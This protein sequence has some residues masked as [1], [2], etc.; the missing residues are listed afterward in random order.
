MVQVRAATADDHEAYARLFPE[1]GVDDPLPSRSR[2][3]DEVVPRALV[4]TEGGVVVGYATY[5]VLAELGYV[6]NLVTDPAHRRRG[7]GRA[8]MEELRRKFVGAGATGWCLNVKPDNIA[9][10]ALYERFGM[11]RAYLAQ[12]L[13]VPAAVPLAVPPADLRLVAV[14]PDEDEAVEAA[15]ALP[16]GQ[17]A[18]ARARGGRQV[19][20]LRRGSAPLGVAVFAPHIPGAF[21]FRVVDPALGPALLAHLRQLAPPGSPYVQVVV[22]DAP[23][24]RDVLLG[25]GAGLYLETVHMTGPL[26]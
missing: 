5:E 19:L 20:Q 15:L 24:L 4:A 7:V 25:L 18:S 13:R 17:L 9:A 2:F 26:R 21:P 22:E 14:E 12:I 23:A 11:R 1:L 8:L 16:R 10:I 6:R 3:A